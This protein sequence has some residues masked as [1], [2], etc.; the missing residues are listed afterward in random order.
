MHNIYLVINY[1]LFL[2]Q[3]YILTLK[4]IEKKLKKINWDRVR[5]VWEFPISILHKLFVSEDK[6]L[7]YL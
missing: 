6:N 1:I 4:K 5:W 7:Y 3:F 2:I